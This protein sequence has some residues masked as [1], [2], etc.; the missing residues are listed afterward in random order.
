M[1]FFEGGCRNSHWLRRRPCYGRPTAPPSQERRHAASTCAPRH[2]SALLAPRG[3]VQVSAFLDRSRISKSWQPGVLR[4]RCAK[5]ARVEPCNCFKGMFM[6]MWKLRAAAEV[7]FP[8]PQPQSQTWNETKK[9]KLGGEV[10][11]SKLGREDSGG[12]CHSAPS[13]VFIH[14]RWLLSAR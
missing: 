14:D 9:K 7:R 12:T 3:D 4:K 2:V 6:A 13:K 11:K 10:G 5:S 8:S 1:C